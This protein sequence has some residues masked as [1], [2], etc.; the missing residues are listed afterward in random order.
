MNLF[1]SFR[2]GTLEVKNRFVR[3]ATCDGTADDFGA[4]T[5]ASIDLYHKLGKGNI[6]LI[7]TGL[8]FVSSNG[9][10]LPGQY[11]VH[12]NELI[13]GLKRLVQT[14]HEGGSKIAVQLVHSGAQTLMDNTNVLAVSKNPKIDKP[15]REMTESEIEAIIDD[16]ASAAER[17]RLAGFDAVQLHG[18]HSYL[19]CQFLSPMSNLRIDQWG[20]SVENRRRFHIEVIRRIRERVGDDFPLWIKF[21]IQDED[22][23]GMTLEEG[24]ET[25]RLMVEEG[26]D[27]IEVSAGMASIGMRAANPTKKRG[28]KEAAYFRERAAALKRSVDVPVVLVGGIRSLA[29]SQEIVHSGDA[30]MISMCR[31]FIREPDLIKR[32]QENYSNES[33]CISCNSCRPLPGGGLECG[34]RE[35]EGDFQ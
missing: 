3:S 25:A 32:W 26:V 14:V 27:A 18:A 4:V 19:M 12:K 23:G 31:P 24:I 1:K 16:F 34:L 8:A 21:G 17:A 33:E 30:D 29:L 9:Q 20:G 2:V 13:P 6:G 22:D 11:G 5:D 28:D 35:K 10:S 15:H 7:I